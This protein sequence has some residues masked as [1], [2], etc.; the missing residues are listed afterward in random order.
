MP[1]VV[2]DTDVVSFIF[3]KDTRARPFHRHPLALAVPLVTH[4][5]AD[6]LGVAGITIISH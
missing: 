4:N 6:Y 2:V 5:P 1:G 3:K